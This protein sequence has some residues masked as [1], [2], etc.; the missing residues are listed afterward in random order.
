MGWLPWTVRRVPTTQLR[1]GHAVWISPAGEAVDL[2]RL[3]LEDARLLAFVA[4]EAQTR[5]RGG[6][7][8]PA[9][10]SRS[11]ELTARWYGQ[12]KAHAV[13]RAD[14]EATRSAKRAAVSDAE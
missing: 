10:L 9:A 7:A 12:L 3:T 8:T 1:A 14:A 6:R 2:G 13:A 5:H 4:Q 11:R